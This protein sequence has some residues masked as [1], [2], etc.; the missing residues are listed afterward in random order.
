LYSTK[1]QLYKAYDNVTNFIKWCRHIVKVK[2]CLMFETED[3]ILNK[4][5]TNFILCLLEVARFGYKYGF[6]VPILIQFELEIDQELYRNYYSIGMP[7]DYLHR[8]TKSIC[9]SETNLDIFEKDFTQSAS[10]IICEIKTPEILNNLD[11]NVC[12]IANKCKCE[13]QILIDKLSEG[14]YRIN[15]TIVFIRVCL[16]FYVFLFFY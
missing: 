6:M 5:E 12:F 9:Q 1:P 13:K 3:L 2:E 8:N 14:K 15:Q 4:N 10:K 11:K 16:L 7:I